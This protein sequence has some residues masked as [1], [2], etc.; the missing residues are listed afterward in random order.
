MSLKTAKQ[1]L[2]SI[3]L[4]LYLFFSYHMAIAAKPLPDDL[5]WASLRPTIELFWKESQDAPH[6][7]KQDAWEIIALL[8]DFIH[9]YPESS[10]VAEA[11]YILGEAYAAVSYFPEAIAHWKIVTRDFPDTPWASQALT[12]IVLELEKKG[13]SGRLRGFYKEI[14]KQ[15]PDSSAAKAAWVS[16][17]IDALSRGHQALVAKYVKQL[18]SSDP[19]IHVTVPRFLDLKA[20][21]LSAMGQEAKARENWLQYL[22]L[23]HSREEKAGA[24]FRIA[25][26]FRRERMFQKARKYYSIVK[27]DYRNLPEALFARFRLYQ[28]DQKFRSLKTVHYADK[29]RDDSD[30]IFLDEIIKKYPTHPLTQEVEYEAIYHRFRQ[31]K[32][33]EVL[34]QCSKFLNRMHDAPF[35]ERVLK[36]AKLTKQALFSSNYTLKGLEEIIKGLSQTEQSIQNSELRNLCREAREELW[37]RYIRRLAAKGEHEKSLMEL[38]RFAKEFATSIHMPKLLE[39]GRASL[40]SLDRRSLNAGTH[41]ELLNFH[42]DHQESIV[43]YLENPEHYLYIG[44]A[45]ESLY[46]PEAAQRAYYH[47]LALNPKKDLKEKILFK[48]AS[49]ALKVDEIKGAQGALSL[50]PEKS[51]E[52]EEG[53]YLKARLSFGKGKYESSFEQAK[54]GLYLPVSNNG[55][56]RKFMK[57]YFDSALKLGNWQQAQDLLFQWE[58]QLTKEELATLF[59]RLGDEAF[60]LGYKDVAYEAYN[61]LFSID[62]DDEMASMRLALSALD[63]GRRDISQLQLQA[64]TQADDP[65]LKKAASQLLE[66][67]KFWQGPARQFKKAVGGQM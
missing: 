28:M 9:S 23:T 15:Y 45:W 51:L 43:R 53:L 47:G 65:L 22:N 61:N 35:A 55:L 20:R 30:R 19:E 17:A 10:H 4:V 5:A 33:I 54:K 56:K 36:L 59:R 21:L 46:C 44:R 39:L 38:W 60:R 58:E 25:E 37:M 7:A 27:L 42:Y 52:R 12:S 29:E 49:A 32:Y 48:L 31:G 67:Q 1:G 34:Q 8:K 24:L 57:L 11:Y 18:E 40:L 6:Q 41:L 14:I 50:L 62:P 16:L 63:T 2:L 64:L 3:C 66:N 26:S 13:E